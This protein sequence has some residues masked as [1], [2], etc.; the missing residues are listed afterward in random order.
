M[1]LQKISKLWQRT[2]LL[3]LFI[4]S[5]CCAEMCEIGRLYS[6]RAVVSSCDCIRLAHT[7]SMS[8]CIRENSIIYK[9][10]NEVSGAAK[11]KS[12]YLSVFFC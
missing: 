2:S 12:K 11:E 6:L 3:S 7:V 4:S 10:A 5:L 1:R 8:H 9:C